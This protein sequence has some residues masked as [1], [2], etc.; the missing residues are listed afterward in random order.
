[1]GEINRTSK[2][3]LSYAVL[4]LRYHLVILSERLY[5]LDMGD[6]RIASFSGPTFISSSRGKQK[7]NSNSMLLY[8]LCLF[9]LSYQLLFLISLSCRANSCPG[10]WQRLNI[11][12]KYFF[13]RL[14]EKEKALFIKIIFT[15][16]YFL[17]KSTK[18]N[19]CN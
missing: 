1:M 9:Q 6:M 10:F 3:G 16:I 2:P 17:K 4:G 19:V 18:C 11:T 15:G 8:Q 7:H 5:T 14:K 12:F 13:Q